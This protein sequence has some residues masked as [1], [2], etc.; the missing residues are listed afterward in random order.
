VQFF[1]HQLRGI[2]AR[3]QLQKADRLESERQA[4]LRVG[5]IFNKRRR[6]QMT[7]DDDFREKVAKVQKDEENRIRANIANEAA[8]NELGDAKY[9]KWYAMAEGGMPKGRSVP[10]LSHKSH[11]EQRATAHVLK[12][13]SE[14]DVE[15]SLSSRMHQGQS[16]AEH[17][18]DLQDCTRLFHF[19]AH[20]GYTFYSK[21][22]LKTLKSYSLGSQHLVH[23]GV[24]E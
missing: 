7:S 18:I 1:V 5:Q 11:S 17:V 19:R 8:R 9:L 4:L 23:E 16:H 21:L 10:A 15:E 24:C 6:E 12:T 14:H 20:T 3:Y 22:Q 13:F 2:N